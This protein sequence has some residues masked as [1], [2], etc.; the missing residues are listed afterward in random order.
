MYLLFSLLLSV[1]LSVEKLAEKK[2]TDWVKI[3]V[4][5]EKY[6]ENDTG[7]MRLNS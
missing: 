6:T 4:L 7:L 5:P 2:N 1:S 3:K